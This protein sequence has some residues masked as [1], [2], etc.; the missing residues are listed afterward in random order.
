MRR[1]PNLNALRAFEAAGRHLSFTKAAAELNVTQGAIS[2]QVASLE[3][4][5][6]MAL[7]RRL[8]RRL[9]LTEAGVAFLPELTKAFDHI[10]RGV[11]E[12]SRKEAS[13]ALKVSVMPSFAARW[14]LPRLSRFRALAPDIDVMV[15]STD[16]LADFAGDEID[17]GIRF[18]FGSYPGLK[19][20]RLMGD[21]LLPVCAPA[22]LEK[23][24]E[25]RSPEALSRTQLLHDD[26]GEEGP[27]QIGWRGWLKQAGVASIDASRGAFFSDSSMVVIAALAGEGVAL[28]RLSLCLDELVAGRLVQPFGPILPHGRSYYIAT[29]Q[30]KAR[31]PKVASFTD[32]LIEEAAALPDWPKA[33][34]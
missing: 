12:L 34:P 26:A 2:H 10:A 17:L 22:L 21:S 20:T 5:L 30:E 18:G 27:A 11:A 6:G 32:W 3:A 9:E 15:L 31:W 14:L 28:A 16:A 24:P 8:N 25:L 23:L 33:S 1:L 4:Q 29:T 13:G 7:F 19:V